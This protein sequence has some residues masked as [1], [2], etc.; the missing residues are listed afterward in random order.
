[1]S[2]H[3]N[4]LDDKNSQITR[5]QESVLTMLYLQVLDFVVIYAVNKHFGP[6][7]IAR[8]QSSVRFLYRRN[9]CRNAFVCV[10]NALC[11]TQ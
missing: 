9:P 8:E 5:D 2:D 6:I 1:V 11:E 4:Q 3:H 7:A 10:Q